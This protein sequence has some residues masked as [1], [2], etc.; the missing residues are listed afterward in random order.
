M[1]ADSTTHDVDSPTHT[2]AHA[3]AHTHTRTHTHTH[4]HTHVRAHVP[5]P[6]THDDP[7]YGG[8]GGGA[9]YHGDSRGGPPPRDVYG[10]GRTGDGYA[11]SG[12]L[13]VLQCCHDDSRIFSNC[14]LIVETL[15]LEKYVCSMCTN[16]VYA[17]FFHVCSSAICSCIL[18]LRSVLLSP[19]PPRTT[20]TPCMISLGIVTS[21]VTS[22]GAE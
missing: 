1:L 6:P 16:A 5:G 8:R 20:S 4:T 21:H 15:A 10:G 17:C 22:S 13:S 18:H 12:E 19:P 3:H 11:G 2:H 7:G 14:L 9:P